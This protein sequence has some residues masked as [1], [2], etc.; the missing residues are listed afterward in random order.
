MLCSPQPQSAA[1][2][3]ILLLQGQRHKLQ[4]SHFAGI[5]GSL[6]GGGVAQMDMPAGAWGT[7]YCQKADP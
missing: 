6:Q 5:L 1:S 2:S 3:P 7:Q 4:H